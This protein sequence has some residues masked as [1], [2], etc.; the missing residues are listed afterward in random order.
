MVRIHW[1]KTSLYFSEY[2]QTEMF[3]TLLRITWHLG[4]RCV[5]NKD[6]KMLNQLWELRQLQNTPLEN[7]RWDGKNKLTQMR[8]I[9]HLDNVQKV[10]QIPL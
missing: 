1:M 3:T 2:E 6:L 4:S 10:M 9:T 7:P 8:V 5:S